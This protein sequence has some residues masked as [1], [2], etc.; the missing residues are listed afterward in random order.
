MQQF[1]ML[2]IS[3]CIAVILCAFSVMNG[4]SDQVKKSILS[5]ASAITIIN[6]VSDPE[7]FLEASKIYNKGFSEMNIKDERISSIEYVRNNYTL[8]SIKRA[9]YKINVFEKKDQLEPIKISL[10]LKRKMDEFDADSIT[11]YDPHSGSA[12]SG[13]KLTRYKTYDN[14]KIISNK[15]NKER[16]YAIFMSEEEYRN[17]INRSKNYNK[18]NINLID[19]EESELVANTIKEQLNN[20]NLDIK[21]WQELKPEILDAVRLQKKIFLLLYVIMFT[22]LCAIIVATSIA[23]FKEKRRDWALIKILDV[24]PYSV[25]KIFAYKNLMTFAISTTVGLILGYLLT[26]YSNEII[27]MITKFGGA[28]AKV[29]DMF[30]LDRISYKFIASDFIIL[31]AFSLFVFCVNFVVLLKVFKKESISNILRSN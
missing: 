31:I 13:G 8:V 24:I 6:K 12:L 18:I 7:N 17:Q 23:F 16:G 29:Q 1:A 25:E 21:I 5:K 3:L 10:E 22:L 2:I 30:G 20:T 28:S 26:I 15:D 19:D 14:F 9:T 4:F 27:S 11:V